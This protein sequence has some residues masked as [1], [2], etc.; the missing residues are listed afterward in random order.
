M[1]INLTQ[2]GR[3][4]ANRILVIQAL[5]A[6]ISALG[7]LLIDYKAAYSAF[8]GGMICLVPNLVFVIYAY[9]Y[10]GARA[11]KKIASS[12]YRGE[13]LKI[14]LTALLFAVTFITTPISIGPLMTTYV[15]C[16][17]VFWFAPLFS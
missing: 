17:L 12:F 11:A 9:R 4:V 14:M 8:I 13:A 15:F 7:F 2:K 1:V 5:I 3:K 6:I 10:G 16:L